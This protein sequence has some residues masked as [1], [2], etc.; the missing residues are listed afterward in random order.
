M[1]QPTAFRFVRLAE[2]CP[3]RRRR[4]RAGIC[5]IV[6]APQRRAAMP[7]LFDRDRLSPAARRKSAISALKIPNRPAMTPSACSPGA[8]LRRIHWVV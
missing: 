1:D 4:G 7:K 2:V 3:I 8:R 6:G 5:L